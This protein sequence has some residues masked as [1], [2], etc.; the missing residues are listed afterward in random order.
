MYIHL[1]YIGETGC[2][3]S[4]RFA[5]HLRPVT[6]DNELPVANHFNLQGYN[7]IPGRLRSLLPAF[8]ATTTITSW[9]TI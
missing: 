4:E 7:S 5:Q 3:L 2:M 9:T 8:P 1:K 6:L